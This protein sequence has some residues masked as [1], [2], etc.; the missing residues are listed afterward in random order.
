M[1]D[2]SFLPDSVITTS[3]DED[4]MCAKPLI[5]EEKAKIAL[6]TAQGE[7]ARAVGRELGRSAQTVTKALKEPETA[8]QV[9]TI[10]ERLAD[11][12]EKQAEAALDGI[13]KEKIQVAGVRDL[14][15]SAGILI[16]KGRLIRGQ[17]IGTV[18][19]LFAIS[20]QAEAVRRGTYID[21]EVV[22][23]E[24]TESEVNVCE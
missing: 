10:S 21:A 22:D 20:A 17:N 5:P 11:K 12:F 1:D 15:V 14:S 24:K 16:D 9:Q 19:V 8:L 7:S 18:S 2:F 23:S 13:T 4:I 6:L 3:T